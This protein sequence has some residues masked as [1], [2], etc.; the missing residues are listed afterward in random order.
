MPKIK[1]W[2]FAAWTGLSVA[3]LVG[4]AGMSG[5]SGSITKASFG[6]TPDGKPV[7]IY[8]LHNANGAEARICNYGGI[9][10]SLKVPDKNGKFGDVVLGYDTLDGYLKSSP[11]FGALIGRYGNRI[12]GATVASV[13]EIDCCDVS[14]TAI[15][16]PSH[17]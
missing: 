15:V 4:C 11:Y 5:S 7:D 2:T 9:I 1:Q 16:R 10:V 14:A 8:T 6:S 12:S 17:H 3:C 13:R